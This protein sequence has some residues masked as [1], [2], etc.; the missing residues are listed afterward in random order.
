MKKGERG[1]RMNDHFNVVE[2]RMQAD[3]SVRHLVQAGGG[4]IVVHED[5]AGNLTGRVR[6]GYVAT[7]ETEEDPIGRAVEAVRQ[8]RRD[9]NAEVNHSEARTI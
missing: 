9:S 8:L 6:S 3:G 2:T 5:P 1:A 7:Y 4:T